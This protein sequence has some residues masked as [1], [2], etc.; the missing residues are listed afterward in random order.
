MFDEKEAYVKLEESNFG[1]VNF[2]PFDAVVKIFILDIMSMANPE[3]KNSRKLKEMQYSER[4]FF[5]N[6]K[7]AV[8]FFS[9]VRKT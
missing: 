9:V 5:I 8:C 4:K 1:Q 2:C 6:I 7:A 3:E